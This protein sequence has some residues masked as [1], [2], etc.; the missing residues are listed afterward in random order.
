MFFAIFSNFQNIFPFIKNNKI[1]GQTIC[2]AQG[3]QERV[4]LHGDGARR[5]QVAPLRPRE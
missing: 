5:D 1:Q 2:G 3:G 4:T